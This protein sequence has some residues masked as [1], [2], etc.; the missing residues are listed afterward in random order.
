MSDKDGR[1]GTADDVV[2]EDSDASGVTVSGRPCPNL[3]VL[4]EQMCFGFSKTRCASVRAP[5]E[6]AG[7]GKRGGGTGIQEFADV[8]ADLLLHEYWT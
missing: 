2:R 6:P 7:L 8:L 3:W 4:R 1:C 5:A